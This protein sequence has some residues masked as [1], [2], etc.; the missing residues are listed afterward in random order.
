MI[1]LRKDACGNWYR[2]ILCAACHDTEV[3]EQGEVCE[4][5]LASEPGDWI[6]GQAAY[7]AMRSMAAQFEKRKAQ[8]ETLADEQRKSA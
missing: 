4:H 1:D 5:C 7:D 2:P 6:D 8:S 3:S